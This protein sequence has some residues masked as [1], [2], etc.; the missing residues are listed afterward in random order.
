VTPARNV[1]ELDRNGKP[2]RIFHR[3]G[4]S[5]WVHAIDGPWF[6]TTGRGGAIVR[7]P[8]PLCE[9]RAGE[10][11]GKGPRR[12]AATETASGAAP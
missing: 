12:S 5:A 3:R 8:C 11:V 2:T 4:T 1:I 9:P 10:D 7:L 6:Q